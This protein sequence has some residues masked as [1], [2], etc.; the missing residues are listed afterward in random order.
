M[1]KKAW[2]PLLLS[3]FLFGQINAQDKHFSQFFASPLSIN[4]ALTGGFT[5]SYRASINYRDQ[6]RTVF[7][8]PFVTYAANLDVRF[9]VEFD[10]RYK[11]AIGVG[12]Q[13]FSDKVGVIDFSTNQIA[14][15]AAFHKGLDFSSKQYLSAGFQLAIAQRNINYES[16]TFQDQFNNLDAFQGLT[17]EDLP[18][19]NFSYFDFNAGINYT[20]TPK[21][22]TTFFAGLAVHHVFQPQLSFYFNPDDPTAFAS[23]TLFLKYSAQFS[24]SLPLNDRLSLIP[25]VLFSKQGPHTRLNAGSNLRILLNNF[26]GNALQI[27]GWV[28]PVVDEGNS[29][30][31]DAAVLMLGFEVGS[32]LFGLSYDSNLEDLSTYQQGQGAIEFSVTYLG[33]Y[34]NDDSVLCPSF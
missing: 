33:D 25:R 12:L 18:E 21:K 23:N 16:L 27:G 26:N 14:I 9:D 2:L 10:S 11:D 1:M 4:P 8:E 19:N 3:F 24:A 17:I 28:R 22:R 34:E 6:W 13:F 7:D 30:R 15:S 32:V 20:F 29:T 5:G 31:V